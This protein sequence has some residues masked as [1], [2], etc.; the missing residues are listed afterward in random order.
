MK[1][2]ESTIQYGDKKELSKAVDHILTKAGL[3]K[4]GFAKVSGIGEATVWNILAERT[5]A[6]KGTRGKILKW[7][8]ENMVKPENNSTEL[9][10][11][12]ILELEEMKEATKS[13]GNVMIIMVALA[14]LFTLSVILIAQGE[15]FWGGLGLI[16]LL[17]Q[18]P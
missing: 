10:I 3:G 5:N 8:Q 7:V 2:L 14:I 12:E 15:F 16:A 6:S 13:V 18:T 9:K 17:S 11:D 4:P 1:N